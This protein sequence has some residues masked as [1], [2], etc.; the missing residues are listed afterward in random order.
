MEEEVKR[1]RG[2]RE[3]ERRKRRTVDMGNKHSSQGASV[4]MSY[5]S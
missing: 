5:P 3:N 2:E 1:E 4:D